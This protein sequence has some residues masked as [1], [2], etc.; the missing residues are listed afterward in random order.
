LREHGEQRRSQP[1]HPRDR[2]QQPDA[3]HHRGQQAYTPRFG[4]VRVDYATQVRTP[5]QSF[6]WFQNVIAR[7]G[8][9]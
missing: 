8:I 2:H 4:L 6:H 7:N 9:D 1:D 3:H 5:K